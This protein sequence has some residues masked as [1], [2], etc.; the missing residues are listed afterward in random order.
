M[1]VSAPV[2]GRVIPLSQVPDQVFSSGALGKGV[3]IIPDGDTVCAPFDGIVEMLPDTGHA[4]GL[5]RADG[6]AMLIHVGIDTVKLN[7]QGFRAEVKEGDEVRA[8]TV[9]IRFE[10]VLLKQEGY[11]PT[12][13]VLVT[14]P[15]KN[16]DIDCASSETTV[17]IGDP[18]L[19]LRRREVQA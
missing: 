5:R 4:I 16:R 7:G 13:M 12:V 9:L 18:V 3:A 19:S 17:G 14:E 11:D 1:T 10:P 15:P 2:S 8:G 6:L